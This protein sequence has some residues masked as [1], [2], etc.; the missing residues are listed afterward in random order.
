M[1]FPSVSA[2]HFVYVFAPVSIFVAL[3]G[4]NARRGPWSCEGLMD[5]PV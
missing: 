2:L 1:A 5:A 4:I 3:S